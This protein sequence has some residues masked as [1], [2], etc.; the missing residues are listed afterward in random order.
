MSREFQESD[1]ESAEYR[2]RLMRKLNCLIA[3]LEVASAKV[4]RSLA[5]PSPD[6]ER[7]TRI[8]TNI[9]STLEVCQRAR[10]ALERR[11]SD[12]PDIAEVV[13]QHGQPTVRHRTAG[14]PFG[15]RYEMSSADEF[16]RFSDM[17]KIGEEE[18]KSV[19]FDD[20]AKRLFD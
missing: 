2:E 11:D 19:D 16:Q 8:Q 10:R 20:L 9:K 17:G 7:L 5:G 1:L 13:R 6:L 15:A 12:S 3:V 14:M 4:Q 18:I